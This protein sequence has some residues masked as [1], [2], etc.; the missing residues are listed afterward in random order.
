MMNGTHTLG[1]DVLGAT[2]EQAA[3]FTNILT[4]L[5][6]TGGGI[7]QAVIAEKETA[8]RSVEEKKRRE[9]R[10]KYTA[11]AKVAAQKAAFAVAEAEA[12]ALKASADPSNKKLAAEAN[13]AA[14]RAT[15]L[16]A[17]ATA[18]AQKAAYFGV[19]T[20][21]AQP[22]VGD[23]SKAKG[24]EMETWKNIGIGAAIA[25]AIGGTLYGISRLVRR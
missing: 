3:L 12:A 8:A 7:A 14:S 17:D 20:T 25:A 23:I 6:K 9:E 22:S 19:I 18:V 11:Q 24:D 10:D 21:S 16:S 1:I 2:A 13:S 4:E 5:T 15:S